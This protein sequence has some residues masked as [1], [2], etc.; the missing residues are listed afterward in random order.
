MFPATDG[1]FCLRYYIISC[2]CFHLISSI[3]FY[4]IF[5]ITFTLP[6][7][8]SAFSFPAFATTI[9]AAFLSAVY[10]HMYS[11]YVQYIYLS[12]AS[13]LITALA[14]S[15]IPASSYTFY[16]VHSSILSPVFLPRLLYFHLI[17]CISTLLT[18]FLPFPL[19]FYLTHCISTFSPVF[20]PYSYISTLSY[21]MYPF[22]P[23]LCLHFCVTPL[24]SLLRI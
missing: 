23:P 22:P 6:P 11:R 5:C 18:V 16:L 10:V 3:H 13:Y 19:Y 24:S 21:S 2:L 12:S 14:L 4:I 8:A 9:L 15:C 1:S 20:L 7:P 17:P